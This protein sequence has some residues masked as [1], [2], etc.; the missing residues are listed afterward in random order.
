M[1][2]SRVTVGLVVVLLV[3]TG[4]SGGA[5]SE[6]SGVPAVPVIEG[7]SAP[8]A[9][10][11]P[12]KVTASD[13]LRAPV[14][15]Y[16]GAL[17]VAPAGEDTSAVL[18]TRHNAAAVISAFDAEGNVVGRAVSV[19][20]D[21]FTPRDVV[22]DYTSTAFTRLITTPP[23]L[24]DNPLAIMVIRGAAER[25]PNLDRFANAI[26]ANAETN[27]SFEA[28]PT[29]AEAK[30]LAALATDVRTSLMQVS[31][32]MPTDG[33]GGANRPAPGWAASALAPKVDQCLSTMGS[34]GTYQPYGDDD[35]FCV[36]ATQDGEGGFDMKVANTASLWSAAYVAGMRTGDARLAGV[37]TP[38]TFA[39]PT[40]DDIISAILASAVKVTVSRGIDLVCDGASWLGIDCPEEWTDEFDPSAFFADIRD[41]VMP[42][43]DGDAEFWISAKEATQQIALL[44]P[45]AAPGIIE[46][47]PSMFTGSDND[48][49]RGALL[50][51]SAYTSMAEPLLGLMMGEPVDEIE[52][53]HRADG[54]TDVSEGSPG[55]EHKGDPE[56]PESAMLNALLTVLK[57]SE[58]LRQPIN[59]AT[60]GIASGDLNEALP[61]LADLALSMF[62]DTEVLG[63]ILQGKAGD[64]VADA[65]QSILEQF[66]ISA[67]PGLGWLN[68]AKELTDTAIGTLNAIVGAWNFI[69]SHQHTPSSVLAEEIDPRPEDSITRPPSS[70]PD[71][72][73]NINWYDQTFDGWFNASYNNGARDGEG[74][75][76]FRLNPDGSTDP[77][78][79]GVDGARLL[80]VTYG[81]IADNKPAALV[82][83][84]T[85]P[86]NDGS[87]GTTPLSI[88]S[89]LHLQLF[90]MF[91]DREAT[92]TPTR[93]SVMSDHP[94][95]RGVGEMTFTFEED[96]QGTMRVVS[97]SKFLPGSG[98]AAQP[99]EVVAYDQLGVGA[100]NFTGYSLM[101]MES[102]FVPAGTQVPSGI[103]WPAPGM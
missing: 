62:T 24:T 68:M 15:S 1:R 28:E 41:A 60:S 43:R 80:G 74:P 57:H 79:P 93:A 90:V 3:A 96:S 98:G 14:R 37:V 94:L 21:G 82:V 34:A 25:S 9:Q 36:E 18:P 84:E 49:T 70:V 17:H 63:A 71:P 91:N 65:L 10:A 81:T 7:I 67:I 73:K 4:C 58:S 76:E 100:P 16:L 75:I 55:G 13:D 69:D 56:T 89:G 61:A 92:P 52:G 11:S 22:V 78:L 35:P 86:D 85:T 26:K 8:A 53:K 102:R 64:L 38:H 51:L 46:Q 47:R 87:T 29:V 42:V 2:L 31:A 88:G 103:T 101:P 44:T 40:V 30:L 59:A 77:A 39:V 83:V 97:Y 72:F 20:V 6:P 99:T 48:V 32:H 12:T 27:P 5:E 54:P 19:R 50:V 45:G 66:T 23:F 95:E 33:A